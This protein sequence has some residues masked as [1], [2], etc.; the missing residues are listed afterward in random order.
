MALLRTLKSYHENVVINISKTDVITPKIVCV[1]YAVKR[2]T[3]KRVIDVIVNTIIDIF[4]LN[5]DKHIYEELSKLV[6]TTDPNEALDLFKSLVDRVYNLNKFSDSATEAYAMLLSI[7][8][9]IGLINNNPIFY[10]ATK[11]YINV[12][13]ET[14]YVLNTINNTFNRISV[15]TVIFY[16]AYRFLKWLFLKCL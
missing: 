1:R 14:K 5:A 13:Y 16:A 4:T 8:E 3:K 10:K 15:T 2:Y 11:K 6:A 12:A 9:Q 7:V